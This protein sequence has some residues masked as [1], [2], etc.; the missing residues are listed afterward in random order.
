MADEVDIAN[1]YAA[2]WVKDAI[3]NRPQTSKLPPKGSCY[4]CDTEFAPDDPLRAEKLFCNTDCS[5]DYE[6]EQRLKNRR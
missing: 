2:R 5:K 6:K 1:D 4:F 3:S